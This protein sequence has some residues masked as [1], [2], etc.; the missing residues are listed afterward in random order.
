MSFLDLTAVLTDGLGRGKGM[1]L[2]VALADPSVL[3]RSALGRPEL[4]DVADGV[5]E[6]VRAED[7]SLSLAGDEGAR[8]KSGAFPSVS[9]IAR[10]PTARR[11]LGPA[12][13]KCCWKGN[14]VERAEDSGKVLPANGVIDEKNPAPEAGFSSNEG[15]LD[16]WAL[17]LDRS[18]MRVLR[19]R[20]RPFWDVPVDCFEEKEG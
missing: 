17:W 19:L 4:L 13:L 14:V 12:F 6:P 3:W 11:N 20:R 8:E 1:L 16:E 5:V 15:A 2:S 7:G 9:I 10:K 18:V